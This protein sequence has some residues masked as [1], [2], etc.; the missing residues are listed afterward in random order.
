M[1]D[2][3][4]CV[5]MWAGLLTYR[6]CDREFACEGCPV[7]AIFRPEYGRRFFTPLRSAVGTLSPAAD[8]FQDPQHLWARVLPKGAVQI[9]LDPMAAKLLVPATGFS[10]P[11]LGTLLKRGDVAFSARMEGGSVS[12][13]SPLAG[14]VIRV[15]R[16]LGER[17][18]SIARH[19]YTR[20]WVMILRA[21][22]LER[23][24]S[25]F[26]FGRGA[27]F[28]LAREWAGFQEECV[29]S[30][31]GSIAG[32]PALPD[33]GELDLERFCRL[34]GSDYPALIGRW[35]G[36]ARLGRR[37]KQEPSDNPGGAAAPP[38]VR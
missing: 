8:R 5:W 7:E 16:T 29:R 15:H 24:L 30:A 1:R 18:R 35:V 13:G 22:R 19:P 36:A 12:F 21:S 2:L 27:G 10:L 37:R 26:L 4:K 11:V 28:R 3:K 33:G 6:L 32:Q 20:G 14:E 17:M 23:Q 31:A 9:G 38:E 34:S 25:R